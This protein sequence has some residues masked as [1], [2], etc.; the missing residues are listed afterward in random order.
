MPF[1]T[2]SDTLKKGTTDA[3]SSRKL[4]AAGARTRRSVVNRAHCRRTVDTG[5]KDVTFDRVR[6]QFRLETFN[7]TNHVNFGLP[8]ANVTLPT[9]G[10]IT[11]TASPP[12]QVQLAMKVLF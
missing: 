11:N 5:T 6:L 10:Q 8:Q 1:R 9:A 3:E 12:L 4:S 7:I 2:G